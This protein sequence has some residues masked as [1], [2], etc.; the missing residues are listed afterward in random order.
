MIT[1][2]RIAS[3]IAVCVAS[4]TLSSVEAPATFAAD[5]ASNA[6]DMVTSARSFPKVNTVKKNLYVEASSTNVDSNSNWGGLEQMDVPQTQSTSEKEAEAQAQAQAEEQAKAEAQ[7]RADQEA[8]AASRSQSR[9]P[10]ENNAAASVPAVPVSA[11]ASALS[12]FATQFVGAP[13]VF[14]GNQPSGWDCSGF[15]QYVFSQ[16]GIS[17][18]HSSGAQMGVGT[19]V[20]SLAEA[21]PGDILANGAHAGIYIG[22]GMVINALNPAQG[23]QITST[24]VFSGPFAIRRVL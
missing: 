14:G 24:A 19:P 5:N 17:L 15:V 13:Y 20:N 9:A 18:P 4:L 2:K 6:S 16:F 23:T 11:N 12:A 1:K 22:N 21:R 10:L 3:L 7:R 8:A